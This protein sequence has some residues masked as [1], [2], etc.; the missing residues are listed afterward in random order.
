MAVGVKLTSGGTMADVGSWFLGREPL[1]EGE[2]LLWSC[3]ANRV[4]ARR[5]AGGRLFLTDKRVLFLPHR[6]DR[7]F[8]GRPWIRER[9]EITVGESSR[10][11]GPFTGGGR[12][13]L[14]LRVADGTD[15]VFVVNRLS[16]KL[17]ELEK[18]L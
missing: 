16:E 12:K 13:K 1:L 9:A 3:N 8:G 10:R 2:R 18:L 6:I 4:L 17:A 7:L 15:E 11:G 14:V 5:A